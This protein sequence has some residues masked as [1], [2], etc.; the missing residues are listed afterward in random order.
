M[1]PPGDANDRLRALLD[2]VEES[3]S[4]ATDQEILEDIRD[5]GRDPQKVAD[6][7]RGLISSRIAAH[8]RQKLAAAR[9]GYRQA[10]SATPRPVRRP[11][12]EDPAERRAL[13]A[14]VIATH[15]GIPRAITLAFRDGKHA[16]DEDVRSTLE[17]LAELGFLDDEAESS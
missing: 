2:A 16:S 6:E 11:M 17:D 14:S 10:V 8:R 13:L 3:I 12:P 4:T 5:E 15:A 1:T 9:K 7:V